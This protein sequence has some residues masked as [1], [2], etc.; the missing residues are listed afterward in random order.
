[1]KRIL[2]LAVGVLFAVTA[3]AQTNETFP[4][5]IQVNGHAEKEVAPDEFYLTI[6][7]DERDSKGKISVEAQRRDMIVALK[8]QGI[9]IE[10]Q[11]KV[12][13]LSSEFFK[14]RVP[15][16]KRNSSCNWARQPKSPKFG[17]RST[18]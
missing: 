17:R 6:V 2:L 13:N 11:L 14:R 5:Y 8:K 18:H 7:I 16:P 15:S 9:N 4:S 10:K 12:T 1:M 3:A